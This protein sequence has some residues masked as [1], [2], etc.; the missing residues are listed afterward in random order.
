MQRYSL[1]G[2]EA[3]EMYGHRDHMLGKTRGGAA[4]EAAHW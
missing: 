2:H 1:P 3:L 4:L